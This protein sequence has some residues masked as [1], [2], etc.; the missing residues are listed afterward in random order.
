MDCLSWFF[1]K[2][3]MILIKYKN[4]IPCGI[5]NKGI[6]SLKEYIKN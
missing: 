6:T 1:I 4:I 3:I 2:C 5:K